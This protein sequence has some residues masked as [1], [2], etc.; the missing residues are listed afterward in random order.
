MF[1][2]KLKRRMFIEFLPWGFGDHLQLNL[3]FIFASSFIQLLFAYD[4]FLTSVPKSVTADI[5]FEG[6]NGSNF[7]Y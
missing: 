7:F 1:S 5:V 3:I 2:D 6:R 4:A